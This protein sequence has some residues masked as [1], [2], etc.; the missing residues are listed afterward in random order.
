MQLDN[1]ASPPAN[2]MGLRLTYALDLQG[3][4]RGLHTGALQKT[5]QGAQFK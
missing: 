2:I 3:Q 1:D 4:P 5:P